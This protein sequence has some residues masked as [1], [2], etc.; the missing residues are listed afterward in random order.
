[1]ANGS[2]SSANQYVWS[3]W[4]TLILAVWLFISPWVLPVAALGT[5]AWDFWIV[6]IIVAAMS[7]AALNLRTEWEDWVNLVLGAWLFISPWIFGY[8]G[9]A[10]AAWNSFIVGALI[11]LIGIWGVVSARHLPMAGAHG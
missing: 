11:F 3:N 2:S 5:W 6:G 8:V 10:N 4:L 1:M 7:I 9:E